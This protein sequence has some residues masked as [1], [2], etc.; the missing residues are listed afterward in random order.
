[1]VD[2]AVTTAVEAGLVGQHL[3]ETLHD[4]QV[5]PEALPRPLE[6]HVGVAHAMFQRPPKQLAEALEQVDA[7]SP[8]DFNTVDR[9]AQAPAQIERLPRAPC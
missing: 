3:A 1:M 2:Q 9:R 5:P 7:G 4:L 8:F 6:A